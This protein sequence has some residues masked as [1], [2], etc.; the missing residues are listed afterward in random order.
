MKSSLHRS[1]LINGAQPCSRL[2]SQG[3]RGKPTLRAYYG[4]SLYLSDLLLLLINREDTR[5]WG[6]LFAILTVLI[7]SS[8]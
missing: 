2:V 8:V 4:K 5:H 6:K 3:E 7:L 1:L